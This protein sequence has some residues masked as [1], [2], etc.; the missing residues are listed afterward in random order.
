MRKKSL[1]YLIPLMVI[2]LS[3][4]GGCFQQDIQLDGVEVREY[5]GEQLSS[6]NDFHENSIK[7]P[8]TLIKKT[9]VC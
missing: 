5:Q 2:R 4:L 6:V 3:V 7:G 8:N 1:Y 9:I